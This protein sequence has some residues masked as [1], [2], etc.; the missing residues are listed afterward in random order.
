MVSRRRS[1]HD[2]LRYV[3]DR[4]VGWATEAPEKRRALAH[5][6]VAEDIT[7]ESRET[8][9]QA[10]AGMAELLER[11]RARGPMQDVP[12]GFVLR[13]LDAIADATID[14]LI[15]RPGPGPGDQRP[16]QHCRV[17]RDLARRRGLTETT[18]GVTMNDQRPAWVITGP[19]SGIGYRTA[20]ELPHT[21]P[22][23]SSAGT[24][25]SSP[26][27]SVRSKTAEDSPHQ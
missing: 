23:C 24:P 27:S 2:Q 6:D 14:D 22:L 20:L 13:I 7:G 17:R 26:P 10:F 1:P 9:H 8:V 21:E 4:W 3:W 5:L 15:A 11:C 16:P 12:L 18:P 19:T 25:T